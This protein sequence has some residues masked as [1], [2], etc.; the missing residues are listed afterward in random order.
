MACTCHSPAVHVHKWVIEK[1][2]VESK[3]GSHGNPLHVVVATVTAA[4]PS[5]SSPSNITS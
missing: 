3:W 1:G 4:G 2:L 5:V